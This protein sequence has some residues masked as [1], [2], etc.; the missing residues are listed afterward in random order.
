MM[1]AS[2]AVYIDG[3]HIFTISTICVGAVSVV[4]ILFWALTA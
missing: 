3:D 4:A 1:K 2:D